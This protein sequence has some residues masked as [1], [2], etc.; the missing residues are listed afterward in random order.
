MILFSILL[1]LIL[2]GYRKIG[3][4]L[5][6]KNPKKWYIISNSHQVC[7]YRKDILCGKTHLAALIQFK[8]GC[9]MNVLY[10]LN[11]LGND[12]DLIS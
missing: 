7:P 6:P 12:D 8:P 9:G 10:T 1:H 5:F 11:R 4:F 3:L 2:L